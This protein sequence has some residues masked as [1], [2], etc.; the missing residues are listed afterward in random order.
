[1]SEIQEPKVDPELKKSSRI[2][3]IKYGLARLVLFIALTV[4]IQA[5]AM[6]IDAPIPL[7]FSAFLALFVALPLSMLIFTSWRM[8]A[9]SSLAELS[10]Q[11]RE[12]KEWVQR[13]LSGR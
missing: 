6:A 9:T 4:I 11:R 1:M 5:I 8:E 3:V 2:A 13:E 10:R 7:P 12:H